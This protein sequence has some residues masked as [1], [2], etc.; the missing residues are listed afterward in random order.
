MN[1]ANAPHHKFSFLPLLRRT[2]ILRCFAL[3]RGIFQPGD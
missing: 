2:Y 1:G 3:W